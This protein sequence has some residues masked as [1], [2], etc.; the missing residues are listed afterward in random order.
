MRMKHQVHFIPVLT[1]PDW[2]ISFHDWDGLDMTHA[3]D[4]YD[5]WKLIPTVVVSIVPPTQKT[6]YVD[7]PGASGSLDMSTSL[8]GWPLYNDREGTMTFYLD[9]DTVPREEQYHKIANYFNR[10]K[11]KFYFWS[12][13]DPDYFYSGRVKVQSFDPVSTPRTS[14]TLEYRF[15]PYKLQKHMTEVRLTALSTQ[16]EIHL[17]QIS[18]DE[19]GF[20][21]T[22]LEIGIYTSSFES[23]VAPDA[24][25]LTY[26]GLKGMYTEQ[27]SIFVEA[28]SATKP[29]VKFTEL[30]EVLYSDGVETGFVGT[31]MPAMSVE[32]TEWSASVILKWRKG[33][34]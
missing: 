22:R 1:N 23:G 16:P 20:M 21:P 25:K 7:I 19:I 12:D 14:I 3:I 31:L 34:I 6:T 15:T 2:D 17:D 10:F 32:P 24:F 30:G 29:E 26:E 13:D 33:G 28:A 27:R 8:T 18:Q 4:S 5:D 11:N 9:D